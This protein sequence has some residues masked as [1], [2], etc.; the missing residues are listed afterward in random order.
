MN[1]Q[2]VEQL[3]TELW[4][5]ASLLCANS[6]HT[7]TEY[8][9]PVL[10]LILLRYAQ[11]RYDQIKERIE[12]IVSE[13]P[14]ENRAAT[15]EDF[16]AAGEI[17]LPLES[18]FDYL[19][20]LPES[21]SLDEAINNAMKLVEESYPDLTGALPK[22]YQKF[23][24][25]LL[26]KLIQV[27]NNDSIRKAKDGIFSRIYEF[28]LMKFA[29]DYA[30]ARKDKEYSS[31]KDINLLMAGLIKPKANMSLY[32]PCCGSADSL[33]TAQLHV[34]KESQGAINCFGQEINHSTW[35]LAKMN[36]FIARVHADIRNGD[37]LSNPSHTTPEGILTKFDRVI[38]QLPFSRKTN[39]AS[40]KLLERFKYG[41]I[42]HSGKTADLM[43]IQHMLAVCSDK[44]KVATTAPSGVLF[45]EG[46]ELD[47]RKGIL[48]DDLLEAVISLPL[49]L[50]Y[51]ERLP[52]VL[53]AF[54]KSK[55]TLKKNKVLFIDASHGYIE[56]KAANRLSAED[57]TKIIQTY[58]AFED[59]GN[60][61]KLVGLDDIR[62]K[63]YN[64]TVKRYVDNSPVFKRIMELNK[65]HQSFNEY[66]FSPSHH[67]C[68]VRSISFPKDRPKANSVIIRRLI[69]GRKDY[70]EHD[71][72][73]RNNRHN[74]FEIVFDESIVSS[75]YVELFFESELGRLAL[76][77]LP[78]GSFSHKLTKQ[79]IE[80]FTIYIP[81]EEEQAQIIGLAR[82]LD[83]AREQLAMYKNELLTKPALYQEVESKTDS[84]VYELSVLDEANRIKQLIRINETQRIEFKQ[85]FFANADDLHKKF[86]KSNKK[87]QHKIAKN[88]A[89]FLNTDGGTLLIGVED[90]SEVCGIES[91]MLHIREVKPEAYIKRLCQ[92]VANLIGERN[93]KW[94]EYSSVEIDNKTII[95]VDCKSAV[96]PVLLPQKDKKEP[97]DFI[98]RR[99]TSS[100]T[101]LG[102]ELLEYIDS[103]FKK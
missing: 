39:L 57:I 3:E 12:A 50:F 19:A 33:L 80:D 37:T 98:I 101:L 70:F 103:H 89:S 58:D 38:C 44:G 75:T 9:A 56:D 68:A 32:D 71:E 46:E 51:G 25:A 49:N 40:V 18:R 67:N 13:G 73:K 16:L 78:S 17:M 102:Y 34:E 72:I 87:E 29:M 35:S 22:N 1:Q 90:N 26:S 52:A 43:F 76:S 2:E 7:A 30:R 14:N 62:K 47:I 23:D 59:R 99:G 10:G 61:S 8:K 92:D 83:V 95:V 6:M 64:L 28:F 84:F 69:G 11:N 88:I 55:D 63:N 100:V 36:M 86:I 82:K 27:F 74:F 24:T 41:V 5:S 96:K 42:S 97:T 66:G 65:Y 60:Y 45:R 15:K 53:L 93:N 48:E 79:D 4:D 31:P 21:V 94:L 91:E 20:E 81:A 85:T 54:N 77:H